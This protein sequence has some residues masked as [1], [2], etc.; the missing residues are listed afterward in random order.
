MK[1]Y[2]IFTIFGLTL[3]LLFSGCSEDFL[4]QSPSDR[5]NDETLFSTVEGAETNLVA[6]YGLMNYYYGLGKRHILMAD[7]MGDDVVIATANAYSRYYTQY[8]F[9]YTPTSSIAYDLYRYSYRVIANA[10]LF[11][12]QIDNASGD[13]SVKEDLKGQ[14]LAARAYAY[15]GLVRWFGETAYTQDSNGRGVPVVTE[16]LGDLASYNLPR[17][18]IQE[19]YNQIILDLNTAEELVQES[20]YKGFIDAY[21]VAAIQAQ[22]YLNMGEWELASSYAKKA[23]APFTLLSEDEYLSGFNETNSETIW[24]QRWVDSDTDIY[25][26][27]SSFTYVSGDI[28]FNVEN[29]A[30][31]DPATDINTTTRGENFVFGYNSFRVTQ[32]FINLFEETDFRKKMFPKNLFSDGT[33]VGDS[34]PEYTYAQYN[35]SK[36]Y[37]AN[38]IRHYNYTLGLGDTPRIR[39]SEMYLIEAE[40]EAN[41]GN[42]AEAQAALLAIKQR[43][44]AT[45]TSITSTGQDL[46]EEI[47]M[48][49]RK[50][51]FY[52]GH[53]FFDLKRL[54]RD[55][56][57]STSAD[58]QWSDFTDIGQAEAFI[59][60][61]NSESKYFCLPIP[62]D[63]IDANTALTDSDQNEAYQ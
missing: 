63:E 46:L 5:P 19:V 7:A 4:E 33:P 2:R 3:L 53:R 17:N 30:D 42:T 15:F 28:T 37:L 55:L 39:A 59:L 48:E 1:N 9:A 12:S 32:N 21:A 20:N 41:L 26:S 50:E 44:D 43:A 22:V 10:N 35:G 62:Q 24:E 45:V 11:L 34:Y 6:I 13:E 58:D 56:D 52:E 18:S 8:R 51:L 31:F 36:G 25:L 27:R 40:A 14:A 60:P 47:Y 16:Y 49:R 61:K 57:R 38:K 23:Y 29:D 54:D